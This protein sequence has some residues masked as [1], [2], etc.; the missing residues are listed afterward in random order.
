M[1]PYKIAIILAI[2]FFMLSP[3]ILTTQSYAA[4]QNGS[5]LKTTFMASD[6]W[7]LCVGVG[8]YAE[9]PEQDR[10]DM[11]DEVTDFA[12]T[13]ID[14][15]WLPDH[16]KVI[17]GE[18]A[19]ERNILAG[20]RWLQANEDSDDVSL[21]FLSTHGSPLLSRNGTPIDIPP[22]D[23]ADKADEILVTYWGF[24][25]PSCTFLWDDEINVELNHLQSQGVC[26]IVDSCYAG[27]FN[28]HWKLGQGTGFQQTAAQFQTGFVDDMKAQNRVILMGCRE[29]E[30]AYSGNFAP[31]LI[32]A[33]RGYGDF[34]HDGVVTAEEAFNYTLP[35]PFEQTPTIYDGYPGELPLVPVSSERTNSTN[36]R[37][38]PTGGSQGTMRDAAQ[39][40]GYIKDVET[41]LGLPGAAVNIHG[42]TSDYLSYENDTVTNESGYYTFSVPSGRYR[43]TAAATGYCDR[44][45][46]QF[47]VFDGQV[48]WMNLSLYPRPEENATVCG[49]ILDTVTSAPIVNANVTLNWRGSSGQ[50]YHNTT[51][52]DNAGSYQ[53][54]AAAGLIYISVDAQGYF[55]NRTKNSSIAS[56][57]TEWINLT[58]APHPAETATIAGYLSDADSG[59]PLGGAQLTYEWVDFINGRSYL[60]ET[61]TNDQ[62]FFSILVAPGE[63]YREIRLNGY[64][65]YDPYRHDGTANETTWQNVTIERSKPVIGFLQPLNALYI[66]NK[67]IVPRPTCLVIGSID[68]SVYFQDM[69]YGGGHV[70]KVEFYLDGTL[71]A[72]VTQEPYN[73]TW[74]TR[75]LGKHTIKVVAYDMDGDS[76]SREI[77]VRKLL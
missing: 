25:L 73:W 66:N 40:C 50:I 14:H 26:L 27:G 8:V 1:K 20:F 6:H 74:S 72:T 21:V 52:T 13:L 53:I 62:G 57:E 16:V 3:V 35:R 7:A 69:F 34:N 28:D 22:K 60:K 30:E 67:R 15:G 46:S 24:A 41:S 9:N 37:S 49:T 38:L 54:H 75:S 11:L 63:L 44:T 43:L 48:R 2:A 42:R 59:I 33:L 29:D 17:K 47:N 70:Q 68:V 12:Q 71:K 18:N 36:L 4:K 65:P 58:L 31:W 39:V 64:D 56:F 51:T 61:T 76:S 45:S 10:P 77:E 55:D 5:Q 32:D 19:T 23:E